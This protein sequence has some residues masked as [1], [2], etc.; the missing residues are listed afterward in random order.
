MKR[1]LTVVSLILL[2]LVTD[3]LVNSVSAYAIESDTQTQTNAIADM[4]QRLVN[5][6]LRTF[7]PGGAEEIVNQSRGAGLVTP[8][9]PKV[10]SGSPVDF[11][12]YSIDNLITPLKAVL[13][14]LINLFFVVIQVVVEIL[15]A[16]LSVIST[17]PS[18]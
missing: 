10:A 13:T 2:F 16:M 7:A 5:S 8:E 9:V 18:S 3:G 11:N 14:L 17:T 4:V 12:S 1:F 15:K 6:V